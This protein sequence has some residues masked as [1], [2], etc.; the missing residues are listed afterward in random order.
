MSEDNSHFST[1][2]NTSGYSSSG[3][4]SGSGSDK[5]D[6]L[7]KLVGNDLC[8][9]AIFDTLSSG[10]WYTVLDLCR[11]ARNWDKSVGIVRVSTIL[12]LFQQYLGNDFLES[13]MGRDATEWR[14]NPDF[15][16]SITSVLS[17]LKPSY[18]S[19]E[20]SEDRTDNVKP[21]SGLLRNLLKGS[22]LDL[23]L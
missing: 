18:T 19:T 2:S 14:I 7:R 6:I 12:S 1:F 16:R 23:D 8:K 22:S 13:R 3:T 5:S 15:L 20:I 10:E 9:R 17:E 11:V 21:P 4:S